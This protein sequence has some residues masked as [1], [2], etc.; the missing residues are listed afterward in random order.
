MAIIRLSTNCTNCAEMTD[1]TFCKIHQVKV[2][3]NY[4][5]DSFTP[6][7]GFNIQRQCTSCVRY[8]S[9]SCAHP[10]KASEGMMCSSWAPVA[11]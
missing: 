8:Q 11:N 7:S 6:G 2:N 10:D 3:G 4:T 1:E 9:E 5:C